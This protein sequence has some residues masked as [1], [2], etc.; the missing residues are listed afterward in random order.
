MLWEG[1]AREMVRFSDSRLGMNE[2]SGEGKCPQLLRFSP[3][4]FFLLEKPD[5]QTC[6]LN[7]CFLFNFLS[8]YNQPTLVSI[9]DTK[10][11]N[12]EAVHVCCSTKRFPGS[13]GSSAQ[14]VTVQEPR[15][16]P[17]LRPLG[18][19]PLEKTDWFNLCFCSHLPI[20]LYRW[21]KK[22]T[23]EM[24]INLSHFSLSYVPLFLFLLGCWG[25]T[26]HPKNRLRQPWVTVHG[27]GRV[28]EIPLLLF[29]FLIFLQSTLEL[30]G[31]V[32]GE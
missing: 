23:P 14:T 28:C 24:L 16:E 15:M 27:W 30:W 20:F 4:P 18:V 12:V 1:I 22:V 9:S 10:H 21:G 3:F 11:L 31:G 7:P 13:I 6:M 25:G 32:T 19:S 17:R 5:Y 2:G 26:I 8:W 29:A